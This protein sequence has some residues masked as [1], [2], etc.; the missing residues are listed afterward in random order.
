MTW[1]DEDGILHA[2]E[3]PN[4]ERERRRKTYGI[5]WQRAHF[6]PGWEKL[7]W[8]GEPDYPTTPEH[9]RMMGRLDAPAP[10]LPEDA[11]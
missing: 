3:I 10:G 6:H 2:G 8:P 9:E 4:A 11:R 7:P 5:W 1:T